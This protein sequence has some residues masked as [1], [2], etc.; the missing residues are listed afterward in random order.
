MR[1]K[2]LGSILFV[3]T[4][5]AGGAIWYAKSPAVAFREQRT[6]IAD[7]LRDPASTQFRNEHLGKYGTLCG[8]LNSKNGSGGYVGFVRFISIDAGSVYLE[9]NDPL[10]EMSTKQFIQHMDHKIK[11]LKDHNARMEEQS[12]LQPLSDREVEERARLSYFATLWEERCE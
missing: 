10:F 8:E 3:A 11:V 2:I 1:A 12:S 4:V 9:G 7:K 5:A 6:F